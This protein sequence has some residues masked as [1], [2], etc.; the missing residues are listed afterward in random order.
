MLP[1][2]IFGL[3][4]AVL[5]AEVVWLL[6]AAAW[7]HAI[8][9]PV[10]VFGA[11]VLPVGGAL[12]AGPGASARALVALG[13]GALAI[14]L[15]DVIGVPVYFVGIKHHTWAAAWRDWST[16]VVLTLVFGLVCL[17]LGSATRKAG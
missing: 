15:G 14:A 4:V 13:R 2:R 8:W 16:P 11:T 3:A 17:M 1:R 6:A 5:T 10:A 9:L 7:H 12:V